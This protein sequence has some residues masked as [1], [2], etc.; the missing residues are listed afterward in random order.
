MKTLNEVEKIQAQVNDLYSEILISKE[1]DFNLSYPLIPRIS[2]EYMKNRIVIIGQETNTWYNCYSPNGDYNDIFLPNKNSVESEGLVKRY[3]RFIKEAA[4][5]YG[6]KFWEFNRQLYEKG[7]IKNKM[8]E[9]NKLSHCWINLFPMEAC[10]NKKD[11]NG[12]PTHNLNLRN[13]VL[14]H[15]ELLIFE[16]LKLLRPKLIIFL[17]G[18]LLDNVILNN[19]LNVPHAKFIS[20]DSNGILETRHACQ[21]SLKENHHL[22]ESK[23]MRLYHPTYFMG[24]INAYKSLSEKLRASN[25]NKSVSNYYT[26]VVFDYLM[27]QNLF[28]P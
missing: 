22:Y 16:I 8:V 12:R 14:S 13:K 6:G 3:D 25:I 20:I 10:T 5:K 19:A 27:K 21:I 2:N 17:T 18:N 24:Y 7:I 9:K 28:K 1:N 11:K 23:I 4:N 26:S 15:Q